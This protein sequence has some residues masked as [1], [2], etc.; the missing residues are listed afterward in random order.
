MFDG[1]EHLFL[2]VSRKL[3]PTESKYAAVEREA[4]PV[5]WAKEEL[6]YYLAGCHF[7][8]ITDHE[9]LHWIAWAKDSNAMET[10]RFLSLQDFYFQVKHRWES[11]TGTQIASP[12]DTLS[13]SP[14]W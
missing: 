11:T 9:P 6:R 1:E 3:T 10:R 7:T 12:I 4:L 5:K 2:Y 13:S 14:V 8:L